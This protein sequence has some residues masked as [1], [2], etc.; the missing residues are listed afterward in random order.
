MQYLPGIIFGV[1]LLVIIT[2]PFTV[3]LH[4]LGHAIPVMLITKQG[5]TVYVGS[6]GDKNH[7]FKISLGELEIWFRYNPL[8]WRGGLCIPKEKKISLN[9]RAI[10]ILCGPLFSFIIVALAFYLTLSYDLHGSIKL[11]CAFA[12][13]ST[14]LDL[15]N[16]LIPRQIKA[17]EGRAFF[18]D[19]YLLFNLRKLKKFPNEYANAVERYEKKEYEKTG[20]IF[21]DFIHRG[22]VNEN[23]Y[24]FASTSYI[25]TKDYEKAYSIQ[26]EFESKYQL[27][28]DDYYNLGLTSSF[29]NLTEEKANYFNKSLEQN[30]NHAYSL[31]AIGYD[32]NT[33]RKFEDAIL[34][35]DKAIESKDDFAYAYNNR[36]H[37]KI[38]IEQYEEGLKDIEQ[39]L[40][41]DKENSYVYRNLGIYHLLKNEK[42]MALQYFQQAKQMDN[43]TDLIDELINKVTLLE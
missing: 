41:L 12:F 3:L 24:R 8:K 21:E 30:P 7:S 17:T 42:E 38:E 40:R 34:L 19:G 36:G 2:R 20:K 5:A 4:E 15:F 18:S 25:F 43:D 6:Y 26:K 33:K 39:S 10:Y 22:L 31:N 23:V 1:F 28:A 29:L 14:I 37:A 9:K 27:N 11:I 16:N 32:L 35:F 13:G